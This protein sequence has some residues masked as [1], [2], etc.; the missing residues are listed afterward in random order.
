[1]SAPA[2]KPTPTRPE[3][4][5]NSGVIECDWCDGKGSY[6]NGRGHGGN[7]PDSCD[8]ECAACDGVGH[9]PCATCGFDVPTGGYDC[10]VCDTIWSLSPDEAA[11]INPDELAAAFAK[12]IAAMKKGL[13]P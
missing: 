2:L 6:W 1:M 3:W 7:D 13:A 9:F 11:R 4:Y 12:C 8:I 10:L 5:R